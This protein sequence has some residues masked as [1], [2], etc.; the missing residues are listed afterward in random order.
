[1]TS[2]PTEA[3][4]WI[5][6]PG[7]T[8]PIVAGRLEAVGDILNF[9]YGRSYLERSDAIPVYL[10]EL[11]L[12]PGLIPPLPGLRA[13]G[14]IADSAPDSW[15]QRVIMNRVLGAG[16]DWGDPASLGLLTY[17]LE[18]GSD[19]FG[20]LDFQAS[21]TEYV[22]RDASSGSLE[23][24]M[25]SAE[26]V[27]Q[28]VPLSPDLDQA[29]LHGSSIGGAR[30]KALLR[31]GDGGKLIAKFS[32]GT[33]PYLV[34]RGEYVAMELARRVGLDVARVRLEVLDRDVLL[35]ERFDRVLGTRQRRAAVSA[36]TILQLD[37][38]AGRYAT[39]VDLA[40]AIRE[41]FIDPRRT[42]RELFGRI[43]FSILVGNTDDHARNHAAFWDGA[44]LALTPA[45]DICPQKRTGGEAAQI[46][47]FGADGF[48]MS[49]VV[50]CIE[51]ASTYLVSEADAHEI[52]DHQIEVIETEWEDVCDAARLTALDRDYF[53]RRQFLNPYALQGYRS[54]AAPA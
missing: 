16:A 10:P 36:L 40:Q 8:E 12:E 53:W 23:E 4:V 45:Y 31:D 54:A 5:W 24:L 35:V 22:G 30:P 11:P 46:M 50:G 37:E 15:G 27:E 20:A 32:S 34:V 47:A 17:L 25:A 19:R 28:R 13:A 49:Q 43:V 14:C 38:M 44:G 41:R 39:Y 6:L 18:S 26:R 48:R 2:E 21:P 7:A 29:L 51:A 1:M 33:D 3:F 9:N 52:V 42:L